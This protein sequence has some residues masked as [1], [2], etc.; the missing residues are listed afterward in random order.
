MINDTDEYFKEIAERWEKIEYE[1]LEKRLEEE[2]KSPNISQ[3]R[4]RE[5]LLKR[6]ELLKK[7]KN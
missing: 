7:I 6:F 5:L 2:L 3:E 4:K 1:E